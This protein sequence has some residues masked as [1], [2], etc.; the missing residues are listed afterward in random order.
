MVLTP[1]TLMVT[2]PVLVVIAAGTPPIVPSLLP[3]LPLFCPL[4][5]PLAC[6]SISPPSPMTIPSI[7]SLACQS[8]NDNDVVNDLGSKSEI[9]KVR[10]IRD[11]S[12]AMRW[13]RKLRKVVVVSE[14]CGDEYI[15]PEYAT[16]TPSTMH[17]I[18]AAKLPT[19]KHPR[20]AKDFCLAQ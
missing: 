17:Y 20:A 18:T 11:V 14:E 4:A 2:V 15:L 5:V 13:W 12:I 10:Q 9:S 16:S 19:P 3:P 1:P 6:P 7:L 8:T